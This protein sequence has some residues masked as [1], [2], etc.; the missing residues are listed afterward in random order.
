MIPKVF[1][2]IPVLN[3]IEN[4]PRLLAGL[5]EHLLGTDYFILFIEDGSVDGTFE[6]LRRAEG[7]HPGRV[8]VLQRAK[9]K[10]GCQRGAALLFGMKWGLCNTDKD[11]F[12]EMDGDLS[13]RPEELAEGITAVVTGKGDVV[14]GSKYQPESSVINRPLGRRLVS[15]IC[16][17]ATRFV[18][19]ARVS[20]Y[21]NGYRFY[22]RRAAEMLL[23]YEIRYGS[24][25]YLS[26]ALA[27][28]MTNGVSVYEFP[29]IYVGRNEGLSKLHW[30]DLG[31]ACVGM[32]DV[33][34]RYHVLG[35]RRP[36]CQASEVAAPAKSESV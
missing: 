31:K 20:D 26:E 21:S 13:H 25:I 17:V 15:S 2:N 7:Q 8:A 9:L 4:V 30:I 22:S 32:L 18:I 10:K 35:F 16:N 5:Q 27:I 24:P 3:E 23:G 19:D 34:L 14:I 6:F 33:A 1:V 29:T 36:E 28:W 12:V 11:I